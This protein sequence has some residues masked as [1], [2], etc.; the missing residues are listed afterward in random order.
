MLDWLRDLLAR[1]VRET[2]SFI[3]AMSFVAHLTPDEAA[4]QLQIRVRELQCGIVAFGAVLENLTPQI[5]RVPLLEAEYAVAMRKAELQW[6][7][8]LLE[9]L[10]SGKLVWRKGQCGCSGEGGQAR[11]PSG[12]SFPS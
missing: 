4:D 1:P 8:D 5:G 7:R 3:A 11:R 12:E 10:R 2:S 6:I 9:D